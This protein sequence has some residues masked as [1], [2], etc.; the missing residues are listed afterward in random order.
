[1]NFTP[2]TLHGAYLI[3]PAPIED[4]RGFFARTFCLQEFAAHGIAMT[5]S[6][7]SVSYNAH[8][9]TLRGMHYQVAPHEEHKVVRCIA[10]S[11][12]DVI[13]DVRPNSPHYRRWFGVELSAINRRALYVPPGMAH[14]FL[15]LADAS[16]VDYMISTPYSPEA[17]R[18]VRWDDP[19][20][21]IA[22]PAEPT[23]ISAR[24]ASFALL[25]AQP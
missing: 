9:G 19:A 11:V 1:M 5:L 12:F 20:F 22:W 16:E 25:D 6:Q 23:L 10:G 17:A 14:G 8:R 21:A 13:V 15:T 24:D 2:A 7:A 4:E 3:D 18:G